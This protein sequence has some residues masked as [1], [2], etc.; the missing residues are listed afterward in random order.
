MIWQHG[1]D[2]LKIF[3]EKLSNFHPSIKFTCEYS[4][5]RVNYLD[6]QLIVREGKLIIDFYVKQTGSHQ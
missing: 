3:L 1:Q 6:I 5:D 2:V 4:R